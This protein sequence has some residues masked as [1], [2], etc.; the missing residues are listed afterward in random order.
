MSD[1]F[2]AAFRL[3]FADPA[4]EPGCPCAVLHL[5][6]RGVARSLPSDLWSAACGLVSAIDHLSRLRYGNASPAWRFRH[7]LR[8]NL[9]LDEEE[10]GAVT[11]FWGA[12]GCGSHP[13]GPEGRFE[14]VD[15]A[16]GGARINVFDLHHRFEGAVA[17][18]RRDLTAD[19][20]LRAAFLCAFAAC[21]RVMI[22]RAAESGVLPLSRANRPAP[23]GNVT[24]RGPAVT[25]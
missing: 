4:E 8:Q 23:E 13:E 17:S 5:I 25:S 10:L 15:S 22:H 20:G 9:R 6:R 7:T 16:A 2:E 14:L 1:D 19:P 18:Y 12:V 21:G 11:R 3:A 24:G